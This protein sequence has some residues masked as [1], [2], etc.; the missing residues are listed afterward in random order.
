MN[1]RHERCGEFVVASGDAS[2]VLDTGKE[3]FD[4]IAVS[5]EMAIEVAWGQ[6]IASGRDDGLRTGRFDRSNIVVG[7]VALVRDNRACREVLE[8]PGGTL[9][10]GNLPGRENHPQRIAQGIDGHMQF[11]RQPA[12]RAADLLTAGFFL[13]PAEC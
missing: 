3:T 12:S 8:G 7:V 4:Q 2:E 1:E 6:T 9:D 10:I 11:G 13:A 5:V